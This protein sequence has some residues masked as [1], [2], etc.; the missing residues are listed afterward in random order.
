MDLWPIAARRRTGVAMTLPDD[1]NSDEVSAS[2]QTIA[3]PRSPYSLAEVVSNYK[4]L[5][6][7]QTMRDK[8]VVAVEKI[9]QARSDVAAVSTLI[10]KRKDAAED[11]DLKALTESAGEI[12][13]ALD[14]LEKLFRVPPETKGIEY[15]ADKITSRIGLAQNYIGSTYGAPSPAART[16]IDI[17][18]AS[19]D[20][21][22]AT[23]DE[24]FSGDLAK[25]R[26]A[27]DAAG[28]GLL[29]NVGA[30]PTGD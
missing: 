10:K 4:S 12:T 21:G 27:V 25:F 9:V 3:D 15:Q 1:E 19:L 26:A 13:K 30:T 7:I 28:I 29:S 11:A 5:L 24:L 14:E 20:E 22:L 6:E 2:A 17:A 18:R 23:V 8:A 16:Y